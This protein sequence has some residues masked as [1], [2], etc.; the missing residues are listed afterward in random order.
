[1]KKPEIPSNESDRLNSLCALNLLDTAAEERFD[2]I[3]RLAKRFF[4][5]SIALV[6]LVDANRQWFKSRQGIDAAETPREISFCG[7]AIL[8]DD[9][10]CIPN[11]MEDERFADNPLVTDKPNIRFYA[12]APLKSTDGFNIGT[13]CVIDDKPHQHTPEELS[14]LRDLADCVQEELR[15]GDLLEKAQ[16]FIEQ[17]ARLNHLMHVSPGVV[18]ACEASNNHVFTF[19]SQNISELLGYTPEQLIADKN[20]WIQCIHPDDIESVLH[21]FDLKADINIEEYEYRLRHANGHYIWVYDKRQLVHDKQGNPREIVGMFLD[22]TERRQYESAIETNNQ[23]LNAISRAHARFIQESDPR[24]VFDEL[25]E[26]MLAL[27]GSE[28]GFIGEVLYTEE[29]QPYLK[30]YAI[31]NIAWNDETRAFYEQNAPTGM[32]FYNLN[33]LF[34]ATLSSGETVIA[35]DPANDS[36]RCG[37]PDGH[38]DLNAFM[39]V[40][41]YVGDKMVG[42]AG[43]A[44]RP[45]GYDQRLVD[46]LQP[47]FVTCARLIEAMRHDVQRREAEASL[48]ESATRIRS[49]LDT[50]V[51]GIVTINNQGIVET[52][53]PASER[54]F[55]YSATEVIGH[56][57]SMLMPE[58]YAVEHDGYL[59]HYHQTRDPRIIGIGR[60]VTGRRKDGT[61]FPM[62]LA[63]TEMLIEDKQMFTGIV[64]D[65]EDRKMV[66][67]KL[68]EVL[69]LQASILDSANF[70]IISTDTE[71]VIKTFNKG[72][73]RMLGY[74]AEDMIGKQTPAIIH[75]PQEVVSMAELL[76]VELGKTIEPGFEVFVARARL[77]DVDENE[78]TYIRQDGSRFPIMLSVTALHDPNGILTGFLG[79]GSDITE[80]KK[81][82]LM[83]S[84]FISTVSHELRT[85]LTSIRGALRLVLTKANQ[86]MSTKAID[87]L[88]MADRNSERLTLLIND[89]L[90]L[91]KME[92]GRLE[93]QFNP[94]DVAVL[95]KSAIEANEGYAKQHQVHL[96]LVETVDSAIVWG[97]SNRLMQVFANLISNAVKFSPSGAV[98]ELSL[99]INNDNSHVA[100]RDH[101]RGIP[102][103]FRS[104]MFTRF[105][106]ADS[107]DSREKGGTGLGLSICK[108]IIDHHNGF[109]NYE[110]KLGAGTN[111]FFELPLWKEN[112]D[113]D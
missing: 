44:N 45:Q 100:V 113:R 25:L 82:D 101:G 86:D 24:K 47:L 8:S 111:F 12:G 79:V 50:V 54:I 58:H 27:T 106:Q 72:A 35:N 36:R 94:V 20:F 74:R 107:S 98:V 112:Q 32:E 42:M 49:I 33:S 37:L 61:T 21:A 99:S 52:F 13:L 73:E 6:S 109:I 19:I 28:Y 105:A 1:M 51:D 43:F 66:E 78:W 23:L 91:E 9:I 71:G 56:N 108:T 90:D 39:G 15:R 62:E 85:P 93:F 53:N 92:S 68:N 75:D 69:S 11:A 48:R 40:P 89:L 83:K 104:R 26:D 96:D 7:H 88:K 22:H 31:T 64:R 55:G 95:I 38:P 84:E 46:F 5:T 60:E 80:R 34:G 18:Y 16:T 81:I 57:V 97:D 41:F 76:S 14:V 102:D 59:S 4:D 30:T 67:N 10:F 70:S 110:T 87:M 29:G 65:I 63:V 77:G 103:E 3:T 17:E 2:R